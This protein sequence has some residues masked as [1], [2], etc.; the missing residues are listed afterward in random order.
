MRIKQP[1]LLR[2]FFA[3]DRSKCPATASSRNLPSY[4]RRETAMTEGEWHGFI[5]VSLVD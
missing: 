1:R 2:L 4:D 5:E 3:F